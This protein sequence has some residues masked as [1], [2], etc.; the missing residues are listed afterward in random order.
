MSSPKSLLFFNAD[1]EVVIGHGTTIAL[2]NRVKSQTT[3]T[4]F[5]SIVPDLTHIRGSDGNSLTGAVPPKLSQRSI[6]FRGFSADPA[7]WESF[8]I[9]L[10]DPTLP[11]GPGKNSPLHPD[12]PSAPANALPTGP[13]QALLRYN[14]TVVLQSLQTGHCSP[15]LVL[16]RIGSDTEASGMDGI[17]VDPNS[18]TPFGEL[19]GDLVAQLQKVAFEVYHPNPQSAAQGSYWLSYDQEIV[20]ERY[21]QAEKRW[22]HLPPSK[23]SS[24]SGS[25]PST[26]AARLGVLPMTPHTPNVALPS[27]PVSPMSSSSSD[28]FGAASRNS[29]SSGL[30]SPTNGEGFFP[31]TDGG[32]ARRPRT[33]STG[34][35]NSGP[36]ARPTTHRSRADTMS[37]SRSY[38]NIPFAAMYS[39][40]T[41]PE[42]QFWNMA[43]GETCVW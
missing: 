34:R 31:S 18:C 40:G 24:R 33:G 41:A 11:S 9:W 1:M 20:T 25:A 30:V 32:P 29:S 12:W 13:E 14:C 4:R 39:Q 7:I 6:F 16:R 43:V 5:L 23:P 17:N 42:R 27:V 35:I 2:F 21:I 37:T 3:S 15:T 10:V 38:E 19:A 22:T 26:P 28:Y 36:F 8:I